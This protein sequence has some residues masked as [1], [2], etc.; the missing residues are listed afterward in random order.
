VCLIYSIT[1]VTTGYIIVLFCIVCAVTLQRG[2]LCYGT[3]CVLGALTVLVGFGFDIN[4]EISF[5]NLY[6]Y[7]PLIRM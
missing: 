1:C 7:L 5:G 3:G 4:Y 6:P 2:V